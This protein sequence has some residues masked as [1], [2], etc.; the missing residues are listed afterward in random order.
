M[1]KQDPILGTGFGVPIDYVNTPVQTVSGLDDFIAYVPHN[2]L[3]YVWMRMGIPGELALWMLVAAA[4]L[5]GTR[6]S[7]S[8][9]REV[10]LLGT[11]VACTTVGWVVMGYTDMGFWWFRAAIAFGCLLGV[12]HATVQRQ[13][14]PPAQEAA[15]GAA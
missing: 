14:S 9:S 15:T 3:L 6:A 4:V 10:A 12:L 5:A 2:T 13:G 11:L 7:R 8:E 1:I